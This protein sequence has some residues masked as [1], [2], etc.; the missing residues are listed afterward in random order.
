MADDHRPI[1]DDPSS[2][3]N[4]PLGLG[5]RDPK[6]P[7]TGSIADTQYNAAGSDPYTTGEP[8][9]DLRAPDG[10]AAPEAP[11]PDADANQVR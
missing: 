6:G 10:E 1:R 11:P 4:N 2:P 7:D 3:E 8:A 9:K 5:A